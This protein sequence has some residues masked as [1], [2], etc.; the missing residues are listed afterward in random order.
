MPEHTELIRI[1]QGIGIHEHGFL[2][3]TF[4]SSNNLKKLFKM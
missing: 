1:A 3:T 4:H 2:P